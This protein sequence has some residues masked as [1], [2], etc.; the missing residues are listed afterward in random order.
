MLAA[1]EC[2]AMAVEA[3]EAVGAGRAMLT[4]EGVQQY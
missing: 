1:A 2:W 3:G 4:V